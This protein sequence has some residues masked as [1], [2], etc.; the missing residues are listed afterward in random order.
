M[1]E[2]WKIYLLIAFLGSRIIYSSSITFERNSYN[3]LVVSFSYN[4]ELLRFIDKLQNVI[5][6][7]SELLF[8]ATERQAYFEEAIF[9][10]PSSWEDESLLSQNIS[11][12]N[13]TW[14]VYS[15]SDVR[16]SSSSGGSV[17]S[18]YTQHSRGCGEFGERIHIPMDIIST[19]D[20]NSLA[21]MFL[22]H[23]AH[24]RYGVFDEFSFENS[25]TFPNCYHDGHRWRFTGCLSPTIEEQLDTKI[26]WKPEECPSLSLR[27]FEQLNGLQS[28]IMFI[29]HL[30]QI[31][32]FCSKDKA[33]LH[34][35]NALTKQNILCNGRSTWEVISSSQDFKGQRN[36]PLNREPPKVTFTYVRRTVHQYVIILQMTEQ[37]RWMNLHRVICQVLDIF[38][39]GIEL[40][41]LCVNT[42]S[43][44]EVSPIVPLNKI[45]REDILF[46]LNGPTNT[47]STGNVCVSCAVERALNM[48]KLNQPATVVL[49]VEESV[50]TD[51]LL[52]TTGAVRL[53]SVLFR[54]KDKDWTSAAI[55]RGDLLYFTDDEGVESVQD[56]ALA[57]T[58]AHENL[59]D[60]REELVTI[61]YSVNVGKYKIEEQFYTEKDLNGDLV[62]QAQC[63]SQ[64]KS[65]ITL[66]LDGKDCTG[67]NVEITTCWRDNVHLN[68][69]KSVQSVL[70]KIWTYT[71]IP[72]ITNTMLTCVAMV[73]VRTIN[74]S[75]HVI[76][77][78]GWTSQ[79]QVNPR[80]APLVIYAELKKGENPIVNANVTAF[81]RLLGEKDSEV[82]VPLFDSGNGDPDISRGDGI[83]SRYYTQFSVSGW[84][85]VHIKATIHEENDTVVLN[86]RNTKVSPTQI[87]YDILDFKNQVPL[88]N[89]SR[90]T[91]VESFHI[92]A[93]PTDEDHYPPNRV[94]NLQ[95]KSVNQSLENVTVFLKWTAPGGDGDWGSASRYEV[96]FSEVP[97]ALTECSFGDSHEQMIFMKS[98][99]LPSYSVEVQGFSFIPVEKDT[100]LYVGLRAVDSAG[101]YG[102]VSNVVPVILKGRNIPT[103]TS[104]S[105]STNTTSSITEKF[106]ISSSSRPETV[107]TT[108]LDVTTSKTS[109]PKENVDVE[110]VIII[111]SAACGGFLFLVILVNAICYCMCCRKHLTGSKGNTLQRRHSRYSVDI[112]SHP[113]SRLSV[114]S[115][116]QER[117]QIIPE[118]NMLFE[119]GQS[120]PQ[121]PHINKQ[122]AKRNNFDKHASDDVTMSCDPLHFPVHSTSET[123]YSTSFRVNTMDSDCLTFKFPHY[124]NVSDK[125]IELDTRYFVQPSRYDNPNN[126]F[127]NTAVRPRP[128]V[129]VDED[130]GIV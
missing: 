110:Q 1:I 123:P 24:L 80:Y 64:S 4:E 20:E 104:T 100:I 19:L 16:M 45:S 129:E 108:T 121:G 68:V 41:V 98:Q 65:E 23:W 73:S 37:H 71:A 120:Q 91:V 26:N 35:R 74:N 113:A 28:S 32:R 15:T 56:I 6:K 30:P 11:I 39:E 21:R 17:N 76:R 12:L 75:E 46:K 7:S 40:G 125:K 70:P 3:N 72:A 95:V 9:L 54:N 48:V 2:N 101:N 105:T 31:T 106:T 97:S 50:W 115:L 126:I 33:F 44:E 88:N 84:Y 116:L 82:K 49:V 58:S 51:N 77:L 27:D 117:T 109:Q 59:E 67:R 99:P 128:I 96:Q 124:P 66:T 13:A 107:E 55:K 85:R 25:E 102:R 119:G 18:M 63:E 57:I 92:V 42:S 111:S 47:T 81:V 103:T 112:M 94:T 93:P 22:H 62:F 69:F 53:V 38:P 122:V 34:N 89:F 29:S 5:E 43:V 52:Q 87:I 10:L 130:L 86:G 118:G 90:F 78:R 60:G 83:Y 8:N 61:H 36:V 79:R 114:N 127:P 14:E